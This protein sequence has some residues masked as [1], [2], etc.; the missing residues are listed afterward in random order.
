[1][2]EHRPSRTGVSSGAGDMVS[3]I[4]AIEKQMKDEQETLLRQM[5]KLKQQ[6][7]D[8]PGKYLEVIFGNHSKQ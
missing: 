8:I 2:K 5:D 1:M 6:A 4:I 7:Q 3:K